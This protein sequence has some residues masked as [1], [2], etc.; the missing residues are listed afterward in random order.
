[1][2]RPRHRRLLP[3]ARCR[4]RLITAREIE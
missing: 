2:P 1:V 4:P 3:T